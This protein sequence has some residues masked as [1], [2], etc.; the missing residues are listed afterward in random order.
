MWKIELNNQKISE[1]SGFDQFMIWAIICTIPLLLYRTLKAYKSIEKRIT[2]EVSTAF[3][4]DSLGSKIFTIGTASLAEIARFIIYTYSVADLGKKAGLDE[5]WSQIVGIVF[6]GLIASF[7]IGMMELSALKS[8]F[9]K[10][11]ESPTLKKTI[12]ASACT[13]EAAWFSLPLI[14]TGAN[15]L[16]DWNIFLQSGLL[17][18]LFVSHTANEGC[19]MYNNIMHKKD[20]RPENNRII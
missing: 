15:A 1:S 4:L 8:L 2:N 3:Q 16:K 6:G 14:S 13:L 20:I 18:T 11:E 7:V 12:I 10:Q 19:T 17:G 5:N 9:Q